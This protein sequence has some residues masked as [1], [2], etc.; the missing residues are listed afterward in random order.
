MVLDMSEGVRVTRP[1]SPDIL[2]V[3]SSGCQLCFRCQKNHARM[4]SW[5]KVRSV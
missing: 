4:T 3:G 5:K 1:G 2:M